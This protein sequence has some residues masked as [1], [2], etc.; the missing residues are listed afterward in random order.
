MGEDNAGEKCDVADP[1]ERK[2]SIGAGQRRCMRVVM[3]QE[4]EQI[5]QQLPEHEQH[6]EVRARDHAQQHERGERDQEEIPGFLGVLVHVPDGIGIDDRP[7]AGDQD[8]HDR[9]QPIDV[10]ADGDGDRG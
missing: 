10:E 4:I 9:A 7:D 2:G 5:A 8:H 6:D 1:Q 3:G